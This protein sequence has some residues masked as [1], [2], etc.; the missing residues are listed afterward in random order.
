VPS[1]VPMVLTAVLLSS[2]GGGV[3]APRKYTLPSGIE[4]TIVETPFKRTQFRISGCASEGVA[5]RING[6]LPFGRTAALPKS[7]VS[8]ITISFAGATYAL[9]ASDMYDA[10]D[11]RPMEHPGS[12]RY[13]G[14]RC[15]DAK[16]CQIRGLFSDGAGTFVAE[17]RVANGQP[18][19]TILTD[20]SDVVDLFMK[21]I[22]PPVFE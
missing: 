4:L 11:G 7:Y 8:S 6:R 18:L 12:I 1:I 15:I 5:C 22:D 3:G 20:S 9:D 21:H 14:G 2:S 17:W 10:W 19:R 13:L 16:N